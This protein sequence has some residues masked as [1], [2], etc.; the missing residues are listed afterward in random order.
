MEVSLWS[1]IRFLSLMLKYKFLWLSFRDFKWKGNKTKAAKKEEKKA[2][3]K[4]NVETKLF[5]ESKRS[6]DNGIKAKCI[7]CYPSQWGRRAI[8]VKNTET[9]LVYFCYLLGFFRWLSFTVYLLQ[10]VSEYN[11]SLKYFLTDR[12]YQLD[13]REV[14]TTEGVIEMKVW[15][16]Q[17]M[18]WLKVVS[19]RHSRKKSV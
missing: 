5:N 18:V 10:P 2:K 14:G 12:L 15:F 11:Y 6:E 9:G 17:A 19:R 7:C 13:E 4:Q 8:W 3:Q 16:N 1:S